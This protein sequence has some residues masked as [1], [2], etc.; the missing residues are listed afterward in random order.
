MITMAD[1]A[2]VAGVS[3][4]TVSHVVNGTRKVSQETE[5][6][7]REAI[8]TTGYTH[9]RIARSLATGK[10]RTIGLA[11]SAISNP[12]FAELAHAIEQEATRAG[13]T[14]LLADTH[15]ESERELRAIRDLL[16]RR[17]DGVLLAPSAQPT[18][19]LELLRTRAVPTVLIDRFVPVELDQ[20]ATENIAPTPTKA[21]TPTDADAVERNVEKRNTLDVVNSQAQKRPVVVAQPQADSG[22]GLDSLNGASRKNV[23]R[24][25]APS[26]RLP[27]P[28]FRDNAPA[29]SPD[30][31]IRTFGSSSAAPKFYRALDGTQS[32]KFSD[33]STR[34][35]DS[36]I[37][38]S[39][40]ST[41]SPKFYRAPDGTQIVKFSD[42][43]TRFVRPHQSNSQAGGS[44]R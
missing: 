12:Y 9:D 2:R 34:F 33:G 15:D 24:P 28:E 26:I 31:R 7:V 14:M 18:A 39:A 6:V 35:P 30:S 27:N 8:H 16:G 25:G 36:R 20:I 3:T 41:A 40:S 42:G 29:P 21:R 44:Y 43:S 5:Q 37:R 32:V 22:R 38:S 1:V 10:T 4:S 23:R 19:A 17:V 11:M 13:Y